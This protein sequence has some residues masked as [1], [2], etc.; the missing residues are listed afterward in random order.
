MTDL[1]INRLFPRNPCPLCQAGRAQQEEVLE[2]V[3]DNRLFSEF[4]LWEA[5]PLSRRSQR[6]PGLGG[7]LGAGWPPLSP[8]PVVHPTD[9]PACSA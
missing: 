8:A 1:V 3:R 6:L 4:S 2:R 7:L 9:N 5:P